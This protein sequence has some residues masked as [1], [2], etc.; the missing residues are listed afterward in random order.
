MAKR[1][2]QEAECKEPATKAPHCPEQVSPERQKAEWGPQGLP[3][4]SGERLW[5]HEM[6]RCTGVSVAWHSEWAKCDRFV[7]SNNGLV[8]VLSQVLF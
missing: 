3:A 4:G 5:G 8:Y 2:P 1:H 6:W 7:H